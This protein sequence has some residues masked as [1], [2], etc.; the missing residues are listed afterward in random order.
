[1]FS[2]AKRLCLVAA[3]VGAAVGCKGADVNLTDQR[4]A[5][6][7]EVVWPA[8]DVDLLFGE[9]V[10]LAVSISDADTPP[11]ELAFRAVSDLDGIL[12]GEPLLDEIGATLTVPT[13]VLREGYHTLDITVSDEADVGTCTR[14]FWI[15]PNTDPSVNFAGPD[16]DT[17][18]LSSENILVEI[19]A[20]DADEVDQSTLELDWNGV[21]ADQPTAPEHPDS[22][23]HAAWFLPRLSAGNYTIGVKVTD[24]VGGNRTATVAFTVIPTDGDGDGWISAS[25]GGADCNDDDFAVNPAQVE[26]CNGIDD[27]CDGLIDTT[28]SIDAPSWYP[29]G[30]GDGFGDPDAALVQCTNPA[31]YGAQGG[32]CDDSD[33]GVNPDA[34][35]VCDNEDND[36][37][38]YIDD[39]PVDG[40]TFFADLDNDTYGD[41][42]NPTTACG[43][44]PG[45]S[46]DG[47][48]CDDSEA[49]ISPIA[50]EVCGNGRDDDCNG[51]IDEGCV[52]DHCGSIT[53]AEVWTA[54]WQHT[55]S[56]RVDVRTTLIIEAGAGVAFVD[57]TAR[58]VVGDG[59]AGRL[60]VQGT[61]TEPVVLNADGNGAL[62]FST[63]D[64]GSVLQHFTLASA[65]AGEPAIRVDSNHVQLLDGH[66]TQG[67]GTAVLV[68]AGGDLLMERCL[69]DGMLSD[70]VEAT[71][72]IELVDTT[73]TDN[74]GRPLHIGVQDL[75]RLTNI[76][77]TGNWVDD[78]LVDGGVVS[79]DLTWPN[80]G[81]P[82]RSGS[83][84]VGDVLNE[85]VLTIEPGTHIGFVSS[86]ATLTVGS[87]E[88]GRLDID[89]AADPVILDAVP[90]RQQ[91]DG[92]SGLELSR[93]DTGTTID[94][95]VVR[96]ASGG[97]G[98]VGSTSF[99][100]ATSTIANVLVE[101]GILGIHS[102][103]NASISLSNATIDQNLGN[104]IYLEG[105]ITLFENNTVTDNDGIALGITPPAISMLGNGNVYSGNSDE[106]IHILG[107]SFSIAD[108]LY[109]PAQG[110][111][112]VVS[113]IVTV[114]G[115]SYPTLTLGDGLVLRHGVYA[116]LEV[117]RGTLA[118][119]QGPGGVLLTAHQDVPERGDWK[120]ISLLGGSATGPAGLNGLVMEWA[121]GFG[122][123]SAVYLSE[124]D[125]VLDGVT[126][127][128][129]A[130]DAI[131]YHGDHDGL[132]IVNCL[133]D[134][135]DGPGLSTGTKSAIAT[136]SGNTITNTSLPIRTQHTSIIEAL[137]SDNALTGNSDD[138]VHLDFQF[139]WE[140]T[141]RDSSTMRDVGVPWRIGLE[142]LRVASPGATP[143]LTVEPGVLVEF[144]PEAELQIAEF[145]N[146][147]NL[148]VQGTSSNPVVFTSSQTSPAPGDWPGL[149]FESDAGGSLDHLIVEYAG[150]AGRSGALSFHD[151]VTTTFS[152]VTVRDSATYG[153][154]LTEGSPP[155]LSGV[156][157]SGNASGDVDW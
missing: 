8:E 65:V 151:R 123:P 114:D 12:P 31:G 106:R 112:Y 51:G 150:G 16:A 67:A 156:T 43:F 61:A 9:P 100:T 109:W 39:S 128:E 32:D 105:E 82:F 119:E 116:G 143:T 88:P 145:N 56:C 80:L 142:G 66:I 59:Q 108:D 146:F 113:G 107:G 90:E 29:D 74:L 126:I 14:S 138:A 81:V 129:S 115:D 11:D 111:P 76:D 110:N 6:T 46:V 94:G 47:T 86:G 95:L 118:V 144:E 27:N 152:D 22:D 139:A 157:F 45:V 120:G 34:D 17:S 40:D 117:A 60:L 19:S 42:S 92:W 131:R 122:Y 57:P 93:Y 44:G 50:D 141:V 37:N 41:A 35:E 91:S 48:D 53:V 149:Q 69:V 70:G 54:D 63:E 127:V 13:G 83:V 18:Y 15:R 155:N 104:A 137:A 49:D 77:V 103:D 132:S 84:F 121:A 125:L 101:Q 98:L 79:T 148:V 89:A 33:P 26:L 68:E 2:P 96:H 30:D 55:I 154:S 24:R 20:F 97:I 140:G 36:C 73:I 58:L 72:S 130:G 147:G 102:D 3:V 134:G 52:I 4:F 64:T 133:I 28:D 7:C 153:A 75:G 1:M 25:D 99:Q 71:G 10:E 124:D 23:G 5:P 21:A 87:V 78:V 135:A 38:G 85:P 136:L 62:A